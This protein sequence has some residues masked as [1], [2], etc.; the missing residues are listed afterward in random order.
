MW[1]DFA[2]GYV[3]TSTGARRFVMSKTLRFSGSA[4]AG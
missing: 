4:S 1:N 3:P 2:N